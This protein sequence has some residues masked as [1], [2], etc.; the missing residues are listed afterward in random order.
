VRRLEILI[1]PAVSNLIRE[2]KTFQLSGVIRT[3]KMH[4][5]ITLEESLMDLVKKR[6]IAPAALP[7]AAGRVGAF[8]TPTCTSRPRSLLLMSPAPSPV[9]LSLTSTRPRSGSI[10]HP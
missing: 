8:L 5:M 9:G 6:W 4:G 7:E 1:V 3:K 10:P 2:G